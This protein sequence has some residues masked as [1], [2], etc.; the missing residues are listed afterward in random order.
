MN[1]FISFCLYVGARVFVQYLKSRPDDGQ[2]ADSLKF[3]LSAMNALKRRNP[4]TE[5]FL[6]QLD[7]DFE[8]LLARIPKLRSAIPRP[9][10]SVRTR[11]KPHVIFS[12]PLT[13]SLQPDGL[14]IRSQTAPAGA[15]CDDPDGVKGILSYRN[16][17]LFM[18]TFGDNGEIPT[19]NDLVPPTTE[20]QALNP[21]NGSS[22]Y[23][24]NWLN[25]EHPVQTLTP[26]SGSLH[27]PA[28][29]ATSGYGDS[30]GDGRDASGSPDGAFQGDPGTGSANGHI[31]DI[32][33]HLQPGQV[34]H[35]GANSF[36]ASPSMQGQDG[37]MNGHEPTSAN[38]FDASNAYVMQ[39]G[40][41]LGQQ[42]EG[43][44]VNSGWQNVPPQQDVP[45]MGDGVLRALMNMGPLDAMDLSTPWTDTAAGNMR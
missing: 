40:S 24:Q 33:G 45:E 36:Q 13:D 7:V 41:G 25:A 34:N 32:R 28:G 21:A 29:G 3:L 5:S 16:E 15:V 10:D 17:C 39:S 31:S 4:L 27:G 44:S 8:A 9:A 35:S 30:S 20:G 1:P 42:H 11:P 37:M 6:V 2:S 18:K 22:S 43:Y 14:K 19:Q 38:L 26:R 12:F 23:G